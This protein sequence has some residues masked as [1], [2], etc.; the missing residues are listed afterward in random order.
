MSKL[1]KWETGQILIKI[2]DDIGDACSDLLESEC[3]EVAKL[4]TEVR[5]RVGDIF[6]KNNDHSFG[7][8]DSDSL[9]SK[10]DN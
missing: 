9:W 7:I 4:L 1:T 10:N 5:A 2:N 8:F 3:D 6:N